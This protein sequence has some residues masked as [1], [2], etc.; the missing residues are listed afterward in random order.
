M[1]ARNVFAVAALLLVLGH[2]AAQLPDQALPSGSLAEISAFLSSNEYFPVPG[3]VFTLTL[4]SVVPLTGLGAS[5]SQGGRVEYQ[6]VMGRDMRLNLPLTGMMDA[7]GM[8]FERLRQ[9]VIASVGSKI[10]ADFV[11]LSLTLPARFQVFASGR[12]KRPGA[13]TVSSLHK[14]SDLIALAGG[15]EKGASIRQVE[16]NRADGSARKIDLVS[17]YRTGNLEHNPLLRPGDRLSVGFARKVVRIEGAVL[18]P[19]SYELLEGEGLAALLEMAFGLLPE[20][21]PD[22]ARLIRRNADGGYE[23]IPADPRAEGDFP[24]QLGDVI[25]IP[26]LAEHP[27][28]VMVEGAFYGKAQDSSQAITYPMATVDMPVKG[29][30]GSSLRSLSLPVPVKLSLP[31]YPGMN[32]YDILEKLGGPTPFAQQEGARVFSADGKESRAFD[33]LAIWDDPEEGRKIPIQP[34]DYVYAPM[35]NQVVTVGGEVNLPRALPYMANR[36]AADYLALAGGISPYGKASKLWLYDNLGRRVRK[37]SLEERIQPED[38]LIVEPSGWKA[39]NEFW[40]RPGPIS[41]ILQVLGF[42]NTTVGVASGSWTLYE[43]ITK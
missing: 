6:A 33:P 2:A 41:A 5:S 43:A 13:Q 37:L 40:T 23:N 15:I 28:V 18:A 3:D 27:R 17:Y 24:L 4:V 36:T 21:Q 31:W 16:L 34:G 10:P 35:K 42:V 38:I 11:E 12:L 7:R 8:N 25:R 32:L 19:G 14:V 20:A 26:S 9:A 1:K 22:K 39:F 30:D 29:S